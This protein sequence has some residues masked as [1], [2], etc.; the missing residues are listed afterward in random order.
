MGNL[1]NQVQNGLIF[2]GYT[3]CF[4]VSF[5]EKTLA[6]EPVIIEADPEYH[7]NIVD[8]LSVLHGGIE[9]PSVE[10]VGA[11]V[12]DSQFEDASTILKVVTSD[13]TVWFR[14]VLRNPFN[15]PLELYLVNFMNVAQLN[16]IHR[17]DTVFSSEIGVLTA[18][19]H[20]SGVIFPS[21]MLKVPPGD[22]VLYIGLNTQKIPIHINFE[23]QAK[24]F[25]ES[26]KVKRLVVSGGMMMAG[27]TFFIYHLFLLF[28]LRNQLYIYYSILIVSYHVVLGFLNGGLF[29]GPT[30]FI[31]NPYVFMTAIYGA[32]FSAVLVT[33]AYFSI[34]VAKNP[35]IWLLLAA[36]ILGCILS[37]VF[38]EFT[39]RYF[40]AMIAIDFAVA[41]GIVIMVFKN[42]DQGFSSKN[43]IFLAC[44][45]PPTLSGVLLVYGLVFKN[46][47]EIYCQIFFVSGFFN[48]CALS[49][50][51]SDKLSLLQREKTLLEKSLKSIIPPAQVHKV[52]RESLVL[53]GSPVVRYVSIMFV[54]IVGYSIATRKQRPTDSFHAIKDMMNRITET[55]LRYGGIIDKSIGDGCLCFFGYDIAGGSTSGQEIAALKCALALQRMTVA[56]INSVKESMR[57][58]V[59]P[60]RI[61]IN[62]AEVCIG[63]MGDRYRFDFTAIGDGVVLANRFESACEPF[64]IIVGPKTFE[65]VSE[66]LGNQERF[67]P[68]L[69]SIKHSDELM[70]SFEINP[71]EQTPQQLDYAR[72]LYWRSINASPRHERYL[73]PQNQVVFRSQFGKMILLNFSKEGLCLRSDIYLGREV[74]VSL[75]LAQSLE[76][77]VAKM[78]SPMT[79]K[80]VWGT[81]S[82]DNA[83]MIGAKIIGL[84]E[85][86]KQLWLDL[87][88]RTCG[89]QTLSLVPLK[90]LAVGD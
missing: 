13:K 29:W 83:F 19:D 62:S 53:D 49:F 41:I 22:S 9:N 12:L 24:K 82:G 57:K 61:G 42:A 69:V 79:V 55:V 70:K 75:D 44:Y 5:S 7:V 76:D 48:S 65:A 78:I 60:L 54:D 4:L 20:S 10:N 1:A 8:S 37:L 56:E 18:A 89:I 73:V 52:L 28:A 39:W 81:P 6:F 32:I 59:F 26:Y 36:T 86:K 27:L 85:E 47:P 77:P 14:T 67:Y 43:N 63:N 45:L 74:E 66:T 51:I 46:N 90:R 15:H 50:L 64:K 23:L 21:Q 84:G 16:I 11:G 88:K 33:F 72:T 30:P 58:V 35:K 40:I 3:L 2:M 17:S 25:F 31:M 87:I 80:V 71:F 68:R 34:S 38:L